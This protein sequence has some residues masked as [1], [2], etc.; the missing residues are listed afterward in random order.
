MSTNKA[1]ME[2]SPE[3]TAFDP[4]K[5]YAKFIRVFLGEIREVK[6]AKPKFYPKR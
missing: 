3:A 5:V 1:L 2:L 4:E 6:L